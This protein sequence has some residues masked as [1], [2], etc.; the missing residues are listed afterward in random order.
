MA[1]MR[2]KFGF[3]WHKW[4][5]ISTFNF[6]V[7]NHLSLNSKGQVIIRSAILYTNASVDFISAL[8]ILYM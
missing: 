8:Y 5:F 4:F 1:I 7:N 6:N 3:I 2:H